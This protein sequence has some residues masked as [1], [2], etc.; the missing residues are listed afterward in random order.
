MDSV[1]LGD[2]GDRDGRGDRGDCREFCDATSVIATISALS[3][4]CAALNPSDAVMTFWV[5]STAISRSEKLTTLAGVGDTDGDCVVADCTCALRKGDAL[6]DLLL[7]PFWWWAGER[8]L[9]SGELTTAVSLAAW[10]ERFLVSI[11]NLCVKLSVSC[12]SGE[13]SGL[14]ATSSG[15]TPI[16]DTEG[17]RDR[18]NPALVL[19]FHR[20]LFLLLLLPTFPGLNDLDGLGLCGGSIALMKL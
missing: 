18:P 3:A 2:R 14:E 11:L 10:G 13:D 15:K 5:S 8:L 19:L 16:R 12:L 17:I 4:L 6:D 20:V 9:P 1:T 7:D